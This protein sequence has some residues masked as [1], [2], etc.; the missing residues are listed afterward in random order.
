MSD[1]YMCRVRHIHDP[2]LSSFCLAYCAFCCLWTN[3]VSEDVEACCC[4]SILRFNLYC[5]LY[6]AFFCFSSSCGSED[7]EVC[8]C[9]YNLRFNLYRLQYS[10]F[11][12]FITASIPVSAILV[13]QRVQHD[14]V[15]T[16]ASMYSFYSLFPHPFHFPR[17]HTSLSNA[18]QG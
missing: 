8:C 10:A 5:L 6:S 2:V 1:M 16:C 14:T 4:I 18:F 15:I 3:S 13:T 11:F 12:C 9:I 17:P 7:V